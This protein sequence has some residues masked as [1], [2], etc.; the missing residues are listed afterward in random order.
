MAQLFVL[1]NDPYALWGLVILRKML[2]QNRFLWS[3]HDAVSSQNYAD[4]AK[5]AFSSSCL[6]IGKSA[7]SDHEQ[8]T[9]YAAIART[10]D[11]AL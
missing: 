6:R 1:K 11:Q 4:N 8:S 2:P 3:D 10:V 5:Q 7:Q 9:K